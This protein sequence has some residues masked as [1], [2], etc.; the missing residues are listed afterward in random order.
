MVKYIKDCTNCSNVSYIMFIGFSF[1]FLTDPFTLT[2][3]VQFRNPQQDLGRNIFVKDPKQNGRRRGEEEVEENHQPVVDHRSTSKSTEELVPEQKVHIGL[4]KNTSK[5]HQ[6]IR[7]KE[8][9]A[10]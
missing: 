1:V 6:S 4:E 9:R 5:G 7:A 8:F 3:P 2:H 10:L